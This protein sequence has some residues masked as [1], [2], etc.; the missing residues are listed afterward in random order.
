LLLWKG[1][2]I[3]LKGNRW[4]IAGIV[5][6]GL[7]MYALD[8]GIVSVALPLLQKAFHTDY[9]TITWVA[10]AYLLTQAAGI[11]VVGYLSDHLGSKIVFV[12]ALLLFTLG[13]L[14]CAL[15]PN[16][17]LLIVFRVLQGIGGGVMMPLTFA[18]VYRTFPANERG[19]VTSVLGILVLMG[20]AIGPTLSGYLSTHFAWNAIF[21]VNVPIGIIALALN[22]RYLPGRRSEQMTYGL[23]VETSSHRFDSAGFILSMVGVTGLVY[24]ITEA[25]SR[26]WGDPQ[27]LFS[28]LAGLIVLI[29]FVI[30]ELRVSDPILDLRLFATYT[31]TL[32]NILL[33]I[34]A[35]ILFGSLFLLPIFFET[36]QGI[37]TLRTGEFLISQGAATGVGIA[38]SGVLYNRM[39]P[40]IL[41][42]GGL[43]ALI[44]GT[45]GLTRL[46]IDTTGTSLQL[47]FVLRGLGLG[48]ISIPLQT[49][50]L[51][52]A[53]NKAMAKASSLVN[54]TQQVFSA[55]GVAL[56]TSYLTQQT[57]NQETAIGNAISKGLTTHQ[58]SGVAATCVR[59]GGATG[60]Q[61]LVQQCV[62]QHSMTSGLNNTFWL[63][64]VVSVVSIFLALILG[65]D[66]AIEAYRQTRA[67]GEDARLDHV[68]SAGEEESLIP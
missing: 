23:A 44:I 34:T 43:L 27:V 13:S 12:S 32:S 17:E 28:L 50:A 1:K 9:T 41:V 65:R 19:L 20:P 46:T 40:R 42:V 52:V 48:F 38:L 58:L 51:S 5:A 11:T 14:L 66:P 36:V 59:A 4:L 25:G 63:I 3:M 10:T 56:L 26:G 61:A 67:R 47:W 8:N 24:G 31:F 64:L 62:V 29:A 6:L 30:I 16:E 21:I 15:A 57:A 33:W 18:I 68:L 60:N 2:S 39:G 22:L 37:S 7:F 49:L 35:S 55:V 54:A 45:Y 53:S